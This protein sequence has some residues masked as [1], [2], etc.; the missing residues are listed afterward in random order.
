MNETCVGADDLRKM[1]QECNDVVLRF[2]LDFVDAGHVKGRCP[3]FFPDSLG[4]ARGDDAEFCQRVAGMRLDLEPDAELCFRGPDGDHF[5]PRIARDHVLSYFQDEDSCVLTEQRRLL[6]ATTAQ[7]K[8]DANRAGRGK[9]SVE[10][11]TRCCE[12]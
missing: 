2:T 11:R 9:L 1:R 4:L 5:R 6:N 3:A 8:R 7:T 10:S 12:L